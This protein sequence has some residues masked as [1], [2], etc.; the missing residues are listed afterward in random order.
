M[1]AVIVDDMGSRLS[2]AQQLLA[3]GVP[4]TLAIIPGLPHARHV[5]EYAHERGGEVMVHMPMEPRDYPQRPLEANGLLLDQPDDEIA[6]RVRAYFQAIPHAAGANNHM[7]SR[8]TEERDKMAVVL[9]VLRQ[10][11][12]F[13]VDSLTSDRSV[14]HSLAREMGLR[15]V[16]RDVFLDN[17]QDVPAIIRQLQA[18]SAIAR[19]HGAAVAIC[20]PHPVTIKALAQ[21]LPVMAASGIRFVPVSALVH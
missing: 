14:G 10:Q 19:R 16:R 1:V 5:A 20:H 6:R 13:F 12:S 17:D 11:Q 9:G 15:S 3:I 18:V 8:F 4:L 21:H 2:E 7:G